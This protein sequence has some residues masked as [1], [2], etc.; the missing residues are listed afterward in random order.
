MATKVYDRKSV[1]YNSDTGEIHEEET[2]TIKSRG[3]KPSDEFFMVSKYI[4]T[5]FGYLEIPAK[6]VGIAIILGE[7]MSYK[8]NTVV[9]SKPRKEILAAKLGISYQATCNLLQE[10]KKYNIIAPLYKGRC[11]EYMVNPYVIYA[12]KP[13]ERKDLKAFFDF[14]S[15]SIAIVDRFKVN[16]E[17]ICKAITNDKK[18]IQGQISLF[19]NS[20]F[21]QDNEDLI[22][23]EESND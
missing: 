14:K 23:D 9:L 17:T 1:T 4:H 21:I 10:C 11:I 19:Q 18:N 16:D 13:S 20:D 22:I 3:L 12:C 5:I 7:T 15:N 2:T 6:L 8:D